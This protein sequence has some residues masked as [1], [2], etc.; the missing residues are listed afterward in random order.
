MKFN[1][2]ALVTRAFHTGE[3]VGSIPTAPTSQTIV[4]SDFCRRLI[5]SFGKSKQNTTRN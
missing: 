3:V 2:I 4:C 5:L 1:N